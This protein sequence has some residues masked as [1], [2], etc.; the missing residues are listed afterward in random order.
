MT[1]SINYIQELLNYV[2]YKPGW[3]FVVYEGRW[4]GA[5]LQ[6]IVDM[7]NAYRPDETTTVDIHCFLPPMETA[8]E[9]HRWLMW[10]L[11]RIEI[12]EMREFYRVDGKVWDDPHAEHADRDGAMDYQRREA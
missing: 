1:L 12:H 7:P 6:I 4:E 11:G 5:H 9:F 3:K 10:R 8:S 2:E